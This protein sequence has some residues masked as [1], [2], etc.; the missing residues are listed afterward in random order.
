MRRGILAALVLG[1]VGGLLFVFHDALELSVSWPVILGFAL[2]APLG[3]RGARGAMVG[4]AAAIGVGVGYA[5]FAIVA[6]FLPI[7][8]LTL[9]VTVG[10][11]VGLLV[12]VGMGMRDRL[13]M[14]ALLIGYAAML[15]VF[16]PLWLESPANVRSHGIESLTVT[17]LGLLLGILVA[18]IVRAVAD[19]MSPAR[20]REEDEDAAKMRARAPAE[21]MKGRA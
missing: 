7:T 10:V 4:L 20:S 16:E 19:R 11:A 13:P 14:S 21:P 1:V 9:G 18:T 8:N 12:L 15:G 5:T 6:E 17:L 3:H 2:W